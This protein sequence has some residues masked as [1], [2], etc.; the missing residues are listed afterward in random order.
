MALPPRRSETDA[1]YREKAV[2]DSDAAV[3]ETGFWFIAGVGKML[4]STAE[5]IADP[6]MSGAH[7]KVIGSPSGSVADADKVTVS[8]PK[9]VT[10]EGGVKTG[11]PL[12]GTE[13]SVSFG[14]ATAY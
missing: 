8:F 7:P 14:L 2:L 3:N 1:V 4:F 13:R 10:S 9:A 11:N 6:E 12:S 5:K